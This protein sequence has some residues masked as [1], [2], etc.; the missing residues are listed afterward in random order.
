MT[1][2]IVITGRGWRFALLMLLISFPFLVVVI[3]GIIDGYWAVITVGLFCTLGFLPFG[4]YAII[5]KKMVFSEYG[6]SYW[7]GRRKKF[8]LSWKD[9]FKLTSF[10][11]TSSFIVI[12]TYGR[13]YR[14]ESAVIFS[15]D[16][17]IQAFRKLVEGT[18]SNEKIEINDY[19]DWQKSKK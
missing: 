5:P 1:N 4:V 10:K 6:V 17:M 13:I 14:L 16:K 2:D 12:H 11:R 19:L 18:Q 9:I 3:I 8:D 15:E 7:I